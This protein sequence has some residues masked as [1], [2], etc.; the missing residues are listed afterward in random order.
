MVQS[1]RAWLSNTHQYRPAC[2]SGCLGLT[3]PLHVYEERENMAAKFWLV[4]VR[5]HYSKG[6]SRAEIGKLKS[7][8][9]GKRNEFEETWHAYFGG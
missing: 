2:I 8:V 5:L 6:F 1:T 3:E 4:P 7:L 9:N